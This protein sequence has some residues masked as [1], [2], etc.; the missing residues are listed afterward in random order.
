MSKRASDRAPPDLAFAPV[1]QVGVKQKNIANGRVTLRTVADHLGLSTT[2]VSRA[3]KHG[4]DVKAGTVATVEAAARALG[5]RPHL[6]GINL[7]TGRTHAIGIILPLGGDGDVNKFV[8]SLIE[9]VSAFAKSAGYRTVV[10][11]LL[12]SDDPIAALKDLVEE[13]SVD[14]IILTNTTPQDERVK[15]LLQSGTPFVTFG[16]TEL[17][18][19]HAFVDVDHECIGATAAAMLLDSGHKM[20]ALLAPPAELTYS[21]QFQRGWLQAHAARGQ[22]MGDKSILCVANTANSGREVAATL[23]LIAPE[24]SA[25]FIA[26]DDTALGFVSGLVQNGRRVGKDFGII[27]YGGTRMHNY[28]SPPLSAFVYPHFDTGQKLAMFLIRL[29]GGED[30]ATLTEVSVAE[31]YD[32]GSHVISP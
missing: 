18:S 26:S 21:K 25:A 4:S 22:P 15:Y 11:P 31:F 12:R 13:K 2:T 6:G 10:V 1:R 32:L 27:T 8:A 9:G 14:G 19:A 24:T 7:R 23:F 5:Y 29:I 3:L 20:P 28:I 17:F 16:R 30:P